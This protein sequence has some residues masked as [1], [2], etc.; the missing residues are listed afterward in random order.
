MGEH[1]DVRR[2]PDEATLEWQGSAA[3]IKEVRDKLKGEERNPERERQLDLWH[4]EPGY[5][6]DDAKHKGRVLEDTKNENID[7]DKEGQGLPSRPRRCSLYP[8]CPVEVDGN[9]GDEEENVG[10]F[11]P[12]IK[13]HAAG[14]E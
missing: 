8:A 13:H 1:P 5:P 9:Q 10:A 7:G 3:Y 11:P 6:R 2:K 14:E 12:S 4:F